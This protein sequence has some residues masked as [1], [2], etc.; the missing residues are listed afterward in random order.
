[1]NAITGFVRRS[2][3]SLFYLFNKRLHCALL[4]LLMKNIT[5]L[6]ST[7][8][9]AALSIFLVLYPRQEVKSTG[10]S[11]IIM[12][13]L[14]QFIVQSVKRIVNRP[15]P[16]IILRDIIPINPPNC[17]YSFPSGHT[18]AAFSI[19]LTLSKSIPGLSMVFVGLALLVALSRVYLGVHYPTDTVI[20]SI[21]AY[22]SFKILLI[23]G[24][25]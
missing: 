6:G 25:I 15:R 2:D 10:V 23:I 12:L 11:M 4:D 8:F 14:T 24:I 9:S 19:A 18:C 20:G 16:Y 21:I 17:K 7:T 22:T 1:M 13:G 3:I 5:H